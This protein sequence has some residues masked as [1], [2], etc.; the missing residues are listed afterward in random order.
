MEDEEPGVV[1]ADGMEETLPAGRFQLVTSSAVAP[2]QVDET[3]RPGCYLQLSTAPYCPVLSFTVLFLLLSLSVL[4]LSSAALYCTF[5]S[6]AVLQFRSLSVALFY[7]PELSL[8]VLNC[9]LLF[10]RWT[11]PC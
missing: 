6:N 3:N 7:C 11:K 2:G 5:I 8:S 10:A 4:S 1:S 9:P